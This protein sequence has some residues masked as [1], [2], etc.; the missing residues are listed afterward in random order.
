MTVL[1]RDAG[2]GYCTVDDVRALGI[3]DEMADASIVE[4]QINRAAEQM[5][6]YIGGTLIMH[7]I[8]GWFRGS[9]SSIMTVKDYPIAT[10]EDIKVRAGGQVKTLSVYDP[11][12]DTGEVD[13]KSAGAGILERVDNGIFPATRSV[14]LHYWAGYEPEDMPGSLRIINARLAAAYCLMR[15]EGDDNPNGLNS[16]GE[17][18]LSVS[19]GANSTKAAE[20]MEGWQNELNNLRRVPYGSI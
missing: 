10:I 11:E 15:A 19:F 7:E 20:L 6:A 8:T 18:A 16:I 13:I 17:G 4:T 9:G 12:T 3:T 2:V 14:Y 1:N 5:D